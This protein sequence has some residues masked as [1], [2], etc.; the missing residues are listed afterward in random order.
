MSKD[1]VEE[2][3]NALRS[4]WEHVNKEYQ[5]LTHLGAKTG[6]GMKKK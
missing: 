4:K 3:K 2:L 1:E 5:S 6:L